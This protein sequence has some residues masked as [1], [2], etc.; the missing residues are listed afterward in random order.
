MKN[1]E[2]KLDRANRP[3]RYFA[4]ASI[5]LMTFMVVAGFGAWMFGSSRAAYREP[6][7]IIMH[8]P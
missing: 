2:N 6:A 5:A 4:V 7:P 8:H 3:D 1:L